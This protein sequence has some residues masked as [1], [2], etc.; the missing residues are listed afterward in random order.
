MIRVLP[1]ALALTIGMA[2]AGPASAAAPKFKADLYIHQSADWSASW[3]TPEICGEDYRHT[4]RGDGTGAAT[5]KVKGALVTFKKGRAGIWQ[6]N[7]FAMSGKLGRQAGYQVGESGNPE[8]CAPGW[9]TPPAPPDTSACGVKNVAKS[10]KG[11]WLTIARGRIAPFGAFT[12]KDGGDPYDAA[13]PDQ[14]LK[15]AVIE[16]VP[17]PQRSDV[18][19][20]IQNKNV[21]SIQLNSGKNYF[22][23]QLT[24]DD[25]AFPGGENQAGEGGWDGRWTLKLTRVR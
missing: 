15:T 16:A 21:R 14:S 13:C 17:S 9:T 1:V 2:C 11:V 19:K 18:D 20:L 8:G 7:E 24:A 5:Y 12:G 6:T 22:G 25:L 10:S 4:F 3:T 23:G